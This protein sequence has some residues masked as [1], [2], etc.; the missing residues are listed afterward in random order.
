MTADIDFAS[1]IEP[2]ARQLLG[3]PN[4]RLSSKAELRFSSHGSLSVEIAGTKKGQWFDHEASEGGGVL[5]LIA[6]ETGCKNGE[7]VR[8]LR[9]HGFAEASADKPHAKREMAHYDYR[10]AGGNLVFQ[11]VRFEP[12]TFRQRRPDENGGWT[13]DVRSVE[14]VPYRLPELLNAA[15]CAPVFICEGEKDVDALHERG[16]VATTNPGGAGKWAPSMSA[17]L[18]DRDVILLPDN[19]E[20]GEEHSVDVQARLRGFAKSVR[21]IRLPG[22]P[23]KGDV[24][25]WLS[26]GGTAEEL[27]RLAAADLKQPPNEPDEAPADIKAVPGL[28]DFLSIDAWTQRDMP[29]ADRLLG[30]LV[31]TTTRVFLVGRTGLGK[32][33]LALGLA[34]GIGNGQGFLHWRASRSGRVLVVD[35]EMP[36]ELIRQRAIDT[37]RRAGMAPE[38]GHLVIYARDMEDEFAIRFPTLGRMQPLNTE[39]GHNWILGLLDALGGVDIVIFDN[40]MSLI[41]GDQKDEMP[42]SD[43]LPLVQSLTGRHVGQIWLDHTGHNSDRQYGSSTKAWRF[44]AVGIM[45]PLPDNQQKHGEVAFQLSFDHPGKARRRT[46]DNWRDFE[47]SVIRLADDCWTSEVGSASG[48]KLK[49]VPPSRKI[50]HDAMLDAIA[51]GNTVGPGQVSRA[52]WEAEC[53]RRNLVQLRGACTDS[54][55]RRTQGFRRAICDLQAAGW[56]GANGEIFSDLSRSY[57]S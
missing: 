32:T 14:R 51:A 37:L 12:K 22:L 48:I 26:A 40:V 31:T 29:P 55:S 52:A 9:E 53:V 28:R 7:S 24:S 8:W 35:G 38:R 50:F 56:V 21:I 45:T 15:A 42:W 44:D 49:P 6:R 23:P 11:V 39:A 13:W 43:T 20:A 54:E 27:E 57:A 47:T 18:H 41:A 19:D 17:H 34:C 16:L 3:E 30:D 33:M 1:L 5:D 2:V 46:P 25:D 36:G 10:D 4:R